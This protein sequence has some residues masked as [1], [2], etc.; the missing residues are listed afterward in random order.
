MRRPL[1]KGSQETG[2]MR[3]ALPAAIGGCLLAAM[4]A[5]ASPSALFS[6]G[7]TLELTLD[8]PFD[9]LFAHAED[10]AEY[11][12]VGTLAWRGHPQVPDG[13]LEGVTI[14]ERG[15]TS[16]RSSECDFP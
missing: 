10:D 7:P 12:I 6:S 14:T 16:R 2:A 9:E 13:A 4:T 1:A 8:A 5:I 11:E 15:H 3:N